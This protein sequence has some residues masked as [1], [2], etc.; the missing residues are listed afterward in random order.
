MTFANRCLVVF[1]GVVGLSGLI[2][3]RP[4]AAQAG[5]DR[6]LALD[7]I[8]GGIPHPDPQEPGEAD[9]DDFVAMGGWQVGSS[10]RL[11]NRA[12]WFGVAASYGSHSNEEVAARDVLVGARATSPWLI[13][14]EAMFRGFAHALVGYASA[15]PRAA[16][17]PSGSSPELVLGGGFDIFLFRMQFDYVGS[18]LPLVP[19]NRLRVF[20]GGFVPLCF[21]GCR[22][23]WE[24]GIPV[25]R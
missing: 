1:L 13:G 17:Q 6:L 5:P 8:A 18:D 11:F 19:R 20:I 24:D 15:R 25:R 3:A 21:R 14:N 23:E 7:V 22:P 10:L 16:G 2:P 12:R 4:A 9:P